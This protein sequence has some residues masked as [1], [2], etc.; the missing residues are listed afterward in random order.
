MLLSFTILSLVQIS[1]VLWVLQELVLVFSDVASQL[2][3][4]V[5]PTRREPKRS[6]LPLARLGALTLAVAAGDHVLSQVDQDLLSI[7]ERLLEELSEASDEVAVGVVVRHLS[8][9]PV[10]VD[11]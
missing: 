11:T 5:G 3:S 8:N 10:H 7:R 1:E 2:V 9:L 4:H 6:V